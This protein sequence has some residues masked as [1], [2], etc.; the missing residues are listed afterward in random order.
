MT[1]GSSR[2]WSRQRVAWGLEQVQDGN[3]AGIAE[4]WAQLD[5]KLAGRQTGRRRGDKHRHFVWQRALTECP[6]RHAA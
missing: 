3:H 6:S 2:C 1:G 5:L 4:A